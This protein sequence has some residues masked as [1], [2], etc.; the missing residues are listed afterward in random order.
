M[1]WR[2]PTN[3]SDIVLDISVAETG[4]V[5]QSA[6]SG[7]AGEHR[8]GLDIVST[9]AKWQFELGPDLSAAVTRQSVVSERLMRAGDRLLA[10]IT[11]GGGDGRTAQESKR[12]RQHDKS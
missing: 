10:V 4:L 2:P 11:V 8:V 6:E 1:L 7:D 12:L 9:L 3:E 5:G